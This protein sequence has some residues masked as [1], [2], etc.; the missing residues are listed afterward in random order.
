MMVPDRCSDRSSGVLDS[1]KSKHEE[2]SFRCEVTTTMNPDQLVADLVRPFTRAIFPILSFDKPYH[3]VFPNEME[4]DEP[5][6][7]LSHA[8]PLPFDFVRSP[9]PALAP[10]AAGAPTAFVELALLC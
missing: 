9:Y 3:Q 1:G 5:F 8:L 4:T 6:P 7:D 10:A 2:V